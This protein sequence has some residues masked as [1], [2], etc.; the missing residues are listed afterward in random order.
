MMIMLPFSWLR[1]SKRFSTNSQDEQ[2]EL[3]LALYLTERWREQAR[4]QDYA[5]PISMQNLLEASVIPIDKKHAYRFIPRIE[6]ALHQLFAKGILGTEAKCLSAI[7]RTQPRWTK[8]WL[9]SRWVLLPPSEIKEH[10]ATTIAAP[11][12][13]LPQRTGQRSKHGK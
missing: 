13:S 4:K 10:Y 5:E 7:D 1:S 6:D 9:A 2:H 8:A 11:L 3:R 12:F